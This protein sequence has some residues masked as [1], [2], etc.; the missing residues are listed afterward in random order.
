MR[1]LKRAAFLLCF[2]A[3]LLCPALLPATA[4][5]AAAD[6]FELLVVGSEGPRVFLLQKRLEDLGF[7]TFRATG[8][9]GAITRNAVVAFQKANDIIVDGT[10]GEET[11]N[12]MFGNGARRPSASSKLAQAQ[13]PKEQLTDGE[14]VTGHPLAWEQADEAMRIGQTYTVTDYYMQISFSVK[15]TGGNGHADVEC[16]SAADF[17]RFRTVFGGAVSWEKRPVVVTLGG[18][19]V[20]ASLFGMPH[21]YRTI[22]TSGM[23]G[24]AC[25][26]FTDSTLGE[27]NL[28][29]VEH[30]KMIRIASGS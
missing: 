18:A 5:T 9:Y 6:S 10:V 25:I 4:T 8:V 20:A 28:T 12:L 24:H 22:S 16:T 14:R 21:G 17:A 13:G 11:Y 29:D 30:E 3:A 7:Y 19:R 15:R 1:R 27:Y 2:A 23:S 26:Y